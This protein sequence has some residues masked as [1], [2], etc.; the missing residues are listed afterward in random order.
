MEARAELAEFLAGREERLNGAIAECQELLRLN[1]N[2]NLGV[3]D[4]LLALLLEQRRFDEARAL[5]KQ[6]DT[7]NSAS[8]M[9]GKALLAFEMHAAAA[10]WDTSQYDTVWFEQQLKVIGTGRV[11][12]ITKQVCKA[13]KTLVKALEFNPWCA[14]YLIRSEE[15]SLQPS[16]P[17][18]SP[19]SREE[20]RL[21]LDY[22]SPAWASNPA[23]L[24]WLVLTSLPWLLENGFE[25]GL[26]QAFG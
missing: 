18:Y 15:M 12:V 14:L 17:S 22:Q 11:P 19:G 9:Y 16:P 20:A 23:A 13:D 2:D 7:D 10:K 26:E 24:Y 4:P 1:E 5:L 6:Y 8:W 3:R 25:S 21:F